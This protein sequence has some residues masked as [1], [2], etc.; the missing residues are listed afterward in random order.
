[1]NVRAAEQADFEA[2]TAL[3][4]LLGRARVTDA[5]REECR[6]LFE[7]ELADPDADH[8]LVEDGSAGQVGF[9]S[10]R[11][12]RRLNFAT[13]EAWVPD[14]IVAEEA[15]GRG[16]GL[17][18]LEEAERRARARGCHRLTLESGR[19]REAAHRL[20]LRFGLEDAGKFFQKR[21]M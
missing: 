11:Y 13:P 19:E 18:L 15:R 5:T 20:Y 14:L 8:L 7:R 6:A 1:V 17:A 3:L 9:C 4:E 2:V 12:R 16:A 10:L 21:L